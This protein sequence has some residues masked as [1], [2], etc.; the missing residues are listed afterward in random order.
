MG[1]TAQRTAGIS[2]KEHTDLS[3]LLRSLCDA[4][5]GTHA[6]VIAAACTARAVPI[7]LPR[8][9]A[10][11]AKEEL[12]RMQ[13]MIMDM[14]NF[15]FQD[16][17]HAMSISEGCI[18]DSDSKTAQIVN[19]AAK[20]RE[21]PASEQRAALWTVLQALDIQEISRA[22]QIVVHGMRKWKRNRR[23]GKSER[24][25]QASQTLLPPPPP[26]ALG[27]GGGGPHRPRRRGG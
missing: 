9:P 5:G 19:V 6:E 17:L 13:W 3:A 10:A 15:V 23:A 24:K 14:G 21:L 27:G 8:L 16:R 11:A 2:G 12:L 25:R 18:I 20:L 1:V 7:T 22:R 26:P 4:N